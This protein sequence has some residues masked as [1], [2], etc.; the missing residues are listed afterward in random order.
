MNLSRFIIVC[1]EIHLS[2]GDGWVGIPLTGLTLPHFCACP[3]TASDK[4]SQS[5]LCSM[6]CGERWFNVRFVHIGRIVDHHCLN[7][8]LIIFWLWAYI[9][10][11][12][13]SRNM[14]CTQ[15]KKYLRSY[16]MWSYVKL[17]HAVAFI[18]DFQSTL[19]KKTMIICVLLE[20]N[21]V[22]C[23]L[24]TFFYKKNYRGPMLNYVILGVLF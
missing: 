19:K 4:M 6:S 10:S 9:S 2:R 21:P 24:E 12:G 14:L 5:F 17:H 1:I 23:I 11:E 15:N 16:S 8:L 22:C 13:Y 20:L 18:F 7:F 3:K